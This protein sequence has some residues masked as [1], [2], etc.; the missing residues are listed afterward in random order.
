MMSTLLWFFVVVK[1]HLFLFTRYCPIGI[2]LLT[3]WTVFLTIPS[4]AIWKHLKCEYNS[5]GFKLKLDGFI[6]YVTSRTTIENALY[7][8]SHHNTTIPFVLKRRGQINKCRLMQCCFYNMNLKTYFNL[9]IASDI[10]T[11]L[12]YCWHPTSKPAI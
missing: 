4:M 6:T 2:F 8:Q 10:N 11:S 7:C 12:L 1:S 5:S 3:Y 9:F